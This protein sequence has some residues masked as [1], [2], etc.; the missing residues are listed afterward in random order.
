MSLSKLVSLLIFFFLGVSLFFFVSGL[1]NKN[2]SGQERA[3]ALKETVENALKGSSGTY[4]IA[5]KNLKTGELYYSNEHR[6]FEA[7]SLYKLWIMAETYGQIQN[8]K[9][10]EDESLSEDVSTLNAEF[11]ID[12]DLAE[13]IEGTVTFSVGDALN[14]MITISHNYAALILTQ[15][16]KLSSIAEF[17]KI[18]GFNESSVGTDGSPPK[19]SAHDILAFY[20]KLYKGELGSMENTEKM[21]SLLKNQQ[22]NEGLPKYLTDISVANKTGD[23]GWFKHDAGIVYTKTGDYIIVVM[24]ESDLPEGAQ[25]KIALISKAVYDYF[26]KQ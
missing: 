12:P 10:T 17:L 25:E 1:V 26:S 20:E 8:N 19:S 14:Q 21:I 11:N 18:Q 13:L 22:L 23:I 3:S 5:I 7:G 9:I 2:H 6:I 4:G 16:I 24:S 15:K